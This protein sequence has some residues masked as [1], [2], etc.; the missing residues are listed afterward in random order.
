MV[1]LLH[2]PLRA[3]VLG[4]PLVFYAL[5][6]LHLLL[7]LV[8]HVQLLLHRLVCLLHLLL[9]VLD[10]LLHALNFDGKGLHEVLML[11]LRA[12]SF[13]E[14]LDFAEHFVTDPGA[15]VPRQKVGFCVSPLFSLE[16]QVGGVLDHFHADGALR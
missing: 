5:V 6:R 11:I 8:D 2:L 15:L 16:Q 3:V 4:Y 13:L 14:L 1:H 9:L 7:L 10:L 12:D